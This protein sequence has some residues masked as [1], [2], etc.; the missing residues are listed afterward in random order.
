MLFI[1]RSYPEQERNNNYTLI[2]NWR[3]YRAQV[4]AGSGIKLREA[5]LTSTQF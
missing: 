5:P 2:Y 1:F 4:I 3:S